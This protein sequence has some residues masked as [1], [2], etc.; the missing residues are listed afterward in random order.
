MRFL[1]VAVRILASAVLAA[2]LAAIVAAIV[3]L[4]RPEKGERHPWK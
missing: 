4:L 1:T 2:H 3:A